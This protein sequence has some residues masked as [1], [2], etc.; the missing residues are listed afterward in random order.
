MSRSSWR[1]EA[2]FDEKP[3]Q[4]G[5]SCPQ[6]IPMEVVTGLADL[7]LAH[8]RVPQNAIEK[9]ERDELEDHS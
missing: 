1:Q 6:E 5:T 3:P 4:A 9:G 8:A 2:L 7:L